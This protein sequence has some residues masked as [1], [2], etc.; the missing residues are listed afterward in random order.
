M[1]AIFGTSPNTGKKDRNISIPLSPSREKNGDLVDPNLSHALEG[2]V[3]QAIVDNHFDGPKDASL[4]CLKDGRNLVPGQASDPSRQKD[5]VGVG[6]LF[7]PV[8]PVPRILLELRPRDSHPGEGRA[9]KP[10]GSS[11]RGD[12]PPPGRFDWCRRPFFSG[13]TP[14]IRDDSP[15]GGG[16]PPQGWASQTTFSGDGPCR[17]RT[18]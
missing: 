9:G 12:T 3:R 5:L 18:P 7:F 2:A 14:D 13:R 8:N 10:L 17:I 15:S 11:T 16:C 1:L 6:H 4:V